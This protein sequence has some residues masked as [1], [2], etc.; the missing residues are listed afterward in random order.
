MKTRILASFLAALCALAVSACVSTTNPKPVVSQPTADAIAKFVTPVTQEVVPF[1][2]EKNPTYAPVLST[3]ADGLTVA[4]GTGQLTPTTIGGAVGKLG[5]GLPPDAVSAI[6]S[7]LSTLVTIYEQQYGL[8]VASATDPGVQTLLKAFAD[9]L[10]NGVAVWTSA[11]P[12][13]P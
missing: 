7:G 3:V 6:A 8:Q 10:H 5:K 13:S 4:F 1:V 9:G 11:H 2:L 12:A